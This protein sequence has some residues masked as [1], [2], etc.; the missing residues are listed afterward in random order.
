MAKNQD[1]SLQDRILVS[2]L[3][4]RCGD[5]A[6]DFAVPVTLIVL[7]PS[8]LPLV[9]F[10]YLI[11]KLGAFIFQP[12]LAGVIDQWKRLNTAALAT[13]LQLTS[14][15]CVAFCIFQLAE[16]T[17]S[18]APLWTQPTL[19]PLL[20]GIS[21]GS[22]ASTLGAGLMD[23]SVGSDWIP[24]AVP[25]H[26]LSRFNSR[27]QR[28]DLLTEVLAPVIAGAI[29]AI[30]NDGNRLTGFAVIVVWNAVSFVPELLIL[31]NVFLSS[32]RLQLLKTESSTAARSGLLSQIT[33]GWSEF[34]RQPAAPAMMAY[35]FLW[36][37]ALSPHGVLLT[38]F[39]KGGWNLSETTLG[40]FRGLGA[41]FGL[42]ATVI[43]PRVR[44]QFGLITA[45]RFF[46][47]FQAL[48]IL[49]SLPFFYT[50]ALGGW[51]FLLMI[52]L[53]RIGLY[54][55]SLGET[56]IR[57]TS[58][59]EGVRGKVNGVA[60]ALTSL[61]TLLLFASGSALAGVN[62]F[63][64][65]VIISA[66]AVMTGALI[67]VRWSLRPERIAVADTSTKETN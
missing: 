2:R 50:E 38:G 61:A 14:V 49:L 13:T 22:I 3:L 10:L 35:A 51:L 55:F 67:F 12:W 23:I 18:S 41:I 5:Q 17:D 15:L 43:F 24:T 4:T 46:I 26:Q 19:W 37:S 62:Q 42:L 59:P 60:N 30:G 57:Q 8:Q 29:L 20:A 25:A 21:I 28:L 7:L 31:R 44:R 65:M 45:T 40:V 39:L 53:S 56:E 36:L 11:A 47:V 64:F 48:I 63:A 52:L 54:G 9:A 66:G 16:K 33:A 27:L 6:W 58:L 1:E 32:K 34:A